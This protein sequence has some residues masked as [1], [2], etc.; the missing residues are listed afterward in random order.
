[1]SFNCSFFKTIDNRDKAYLLGLM[2][3]DISLNSKITINKSSIP[4]GFITAM[5]MDQDNYTFTNTEIII[6][7][8]QMVNDI[9]EQLLTHEMPDI[10]DDLIYHFIRGIFES[11]GSISPKRRFCVFSVPKNK[12]A[13]IAKLCKPTRIDD[14]NS[15]VFEGTTAVDFLSKL[16]DSLDSNDETFSHTSCDIYLDYIGCKGSGIPVCEFIKIV[17]TAFSPSK[18]RAT[19][20]GYDLHLISVDKQISAITT[21]YDTGLIIVPPDNWHVEVLP[22]SSLSNSGYMLANSVGLIDES[23]RGSI[24]VVLTKI[25]PSAKDLE[26]PFKAVQIVLRKSYHFLCDEASSIKDQTDRGSG[27]FGSTN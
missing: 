13:P 6:D 4:K 25:D 17:P 9:T 10:S 19:D 20:E 12:V 16:Y 5:A 21:R 26:L 27:G 14:E 1:M 23:Y 7:S 8:Q 24:K 18:G 2:V 22:R 15:L 11:V 3:N